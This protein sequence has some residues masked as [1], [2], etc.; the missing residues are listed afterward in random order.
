MALGP[1]HE[2]KTPI[3]PRRPLRS[4]VMHTQASKIGEWTRIEVLVTVKAYPSIS[5]KYG[6]AI[7]VAGVRLDS[8]KPQWVRLFP[9]PF[10]D[11][12][13]SKQFGKYEIIT[14]RACRHSTDRRAETWRPDVESIE[15]GP[16]LPAGGAWLARR[17]HLEPLIGPT[18][19]DL[20]HG[21]KG[22][23]AGPS[24]GLVRP[25]RI[26]SIRVEPESEWSPGQL[27][28][29][30][31]QNLLTH[32]SQLVKPGHAFSYSYLCASP[33]C[34]GHV[35]K[36]VDW[37]LGEAYRTWSPHGDELVAMIRRR[38]LDDM[39]H[40]KRETMFFVGDQH[41]R[42][43]KFLVLGTFYPERRPNEHQ[44]TLDLAA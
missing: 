6:E 36:I 21:R 31:Q 41:T 16:M 28:V 35:Q 33:G 10:R 4:L 12:P 30:G 29:A 37:E 5:T 27:G 7:C 42:P 2:P 8:A 15:R 40:E 13:L 34:K 24:L 38:W 19:C 23:G 26:R 20:H 9:V 17:P 44:L 1:E 25:A 14:L 3:E 32:K 18:M 39:C 43:G 11:L 22:G